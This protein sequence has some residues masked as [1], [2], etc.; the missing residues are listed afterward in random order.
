[1]KCTVTEPAGGIPTGW[2][3]KSIS[4]AGEF[5]VGSGASVVVDV[6]NKRLVGS[7]TVNKLRQGDVAGASTEFTFDLNCDG[8]DY[9]HIGIV[10]NS[11]NSWTKTYTNIPS[12]V[13]CTVTEPAGSIP[14]GW[15]LMSI[16]P[17]GEFTI[18][19]GQTV[20]VDITNKRL[21]GDLTI[22]KL[23]EGDVAGASTE[24]TVDLDC[25]VNDYDHFGIV[26]NSGN[27]WTQ[28]Y[29]NIPSGVKCTVTES[30]AGIPAGWEL[31]SISPSGEFTIAA[32]QTVTVNVTNK[33]LLGGVVINKVL[34]G[35]VAGA[36]TEFTVLLNCD[37]TAYDHTVVLNSG[38]SWTQSFLTIPAGVK[39]TVTEPAG[40]IPAGWELKSIDPAGEF[41][42]GS[43]ASVVVDVT[44]GRLV[45]K[46]RS[47]RCCPV[48]W[49]VRTRASRRTWTARAR[50]TTRTLL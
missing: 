10:L 41:T 2:E 16:N 9:D 4:P 47:R 29:A 26:L 25:N 38:N 22:N 11:G 34:E 45:G 36:A 8:T 24:F 1:M 32:G 23:L 49:R 39:C 12:G 27:A 14:A 50:T 33:R 30:A 35:D 40:G 19:A 20:T 46:L 44:N 7:V 6:T 5:T 17:A 13:K 42:V 18:G 37:G 28:T 48:M 15:E 21:V 31:K 43:E 3:L